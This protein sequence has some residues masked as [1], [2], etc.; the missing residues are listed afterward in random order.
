MKTELSK[1]L[2]PRDKGRITESELT[3]NPENLSDYNQGLNHGL[4]LAL[5]AKELGLSNQEIIKRY[6]KQ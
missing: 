6:K 2:D 1:S 4:E 5:A 3:P